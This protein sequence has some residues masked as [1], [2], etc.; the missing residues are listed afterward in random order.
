MGNLLNNNNE[1][2]SRTSTCTTSK[3]TIYTKPY[4]PSGT[5]V[6]KE[7]A[8]QASDIKISDNIV[9]CAV[10]ASVCQQEKLTHM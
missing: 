1:D 8:K 4:S 2:H 3:M 5:V 7:G 10:L 9:Q 6:A